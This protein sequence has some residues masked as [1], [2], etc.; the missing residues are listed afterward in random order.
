VTDERTNR[1]SSGRVNWILEVQAENARLRLMIWRVAFV[2]F[3]LG[4]VVTA[5]A[6]AVI[7][8]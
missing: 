7:S 3:A 2:G 4:V 5:I 1:F 8:P 6:A